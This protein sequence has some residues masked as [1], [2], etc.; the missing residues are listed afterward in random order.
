MT[1]RVHTPR[2][3]TVANKLVRCSEHNAW[4][5]E[6][7]RSLDRRTQEHGVEHLASDLILVRLMRSEAESVVCGDEGWRGRSGHRGPGSV[8]APRTV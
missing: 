2:A 6:Q 3:I 8:C 4:R 1:F 7:A 5:V